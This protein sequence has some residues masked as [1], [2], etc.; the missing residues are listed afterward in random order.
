MEKFTILRIKILHHDCFS[1]TLSLIAST[2]L[3]ITLNLIKIFLSAEKVRMGHY[4]LIHPSKNFNL[5]PSLAY[6]YHNCLSYT[7]YRKFHG[8]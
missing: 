3:R 4:G 7:L 1:N 2:E 5:F 8:S 6:Y